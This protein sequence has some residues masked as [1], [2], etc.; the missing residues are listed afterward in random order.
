MPP[1]QLKALTS[2]FEP[3]ILVFLGLMVGGIAISRFMPMF[4]LTSMAGGG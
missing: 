3:L 4:D 2:L 1:K